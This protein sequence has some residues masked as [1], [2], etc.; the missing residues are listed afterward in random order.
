MFYNKLY[1]LIFSITPII[2]SAQSFTEMTEALD[3]GVKGFNRGVA[4][5]DFDNDGL[6]D[7]YISRLEAR[8]LLYR[9]LGNFEFEE[10]AAKYGVDSDRSTNASLFFDM[11]NDGDL[12][13]YLVNSFQRD[14]LYRNDVDSFADVSD[15]FAVGRDFGNVK[16]A[17]AADYDMDGDLDIYVTSFRSQNVLWR[18]EGTHFLNVIASSG[19]DDKGSSLGAI[20]VDYD[21]DGDQDLYQTRDGTDANLFFVNDGSGKYT[22]QSASMGL[23]FVG[24][25]MG[26]D[27]CEINGDGEPDLYLTNLEENKLYI[28]DGTGSFDEISGSSTVDD[29]GMGWSCFF[30]DCDN[31][32]LEDLYVAN[33]SYFG[34]NGKS[35]VRNRL[36]MNTGGQS[37]HSEDYIGNVQNEYGTYG[38]AFGDLDNDGKLDLV[39]ANHGT[40]DGNQIFRNTGSAANFVQIKLQGTLSNSYGIGARLQLYTAGGVQSEFVNCGSGYASQNSFISHFGLGDQDEVDSLI[41]YWPSGVTQVVS[42]VSVNTRSTVVEDPNYP[43]GEVVWTEPELPTIDDDITVYY[44]AAEGNGE[45]AGFDGTVYA[46]AGVITNQSSSPTDWKHVVGNWGTPD[47]RVRMTRVMD[48]VYT[49]SYNIRDFY[50]IPDGEIVEQLA[51]VFRNADG[52]LVGRDSDGSDIYT[53]VAPSDGLFMIVNSPSTNA[54]VRPGDSLLVDA[55]SNQS[56]FWTITNNG[57]TI[58][59]DSAEAVNIYITPDQI[60]AQSLEIT[61]I[62]EGD[63]ARYEAD[64]YAASPHTY[65]AA[66]DGVRDGLNYTDSS[67]IFQLYAPDKAFGYLLCPAN[68]FNWH[69]DFRMMRSPDSASFWIE[70]PRE[71]FSGQDQNTYQYGTEGAIIADPYSGIVLDPS[72]DNWI[73][74]HVKAELPAYPAN[75]RGRIVSVLDTIPLNYDWQVDSFVKPAKE[76]LVIYELLVR[77]F[78]EDR[79]Y[80]SLLDTLDYLEDLGVNAI[81]LMPVNE[82]EANISWGYN[83][84]FHHALDKYYGTRDDLKR[85][86]D[87]AHS[88]GMAVIIDV[89]FNHSFG[90]GPL[91]RLYWD[92]DASRPAAGSPYLNVVP[93]HP[94]NV[95]FDFNHESYPTVYFVKRTL[96]H[97]LSEY[98]VDG[99]RFDLSKGFT[100]RFSGNNAALM[101][102]YD[103]KR[104]AR[105]KDYADHVWSIDTQAYVILE[106]YAENSE[107]TELA[108][109]GMMIWGKADFE[110]A[111][112]AMGYESTLEWS[113]YTVRGW[114]DPHVVSYMESHDEERMAYKIQRWGDQ[115]A[116]YDTRE[117]STAMER[118]AAAAAIFYTI[119]GPKML[120]QFGELGYDY[121]VNYC[122]NGEIDEG[123]RTEPKPITWHYLNNEARAKLRAK[124]KAMIHLKTTYPT[125]SS[126]DFTFN[127]GNSYLKSIQLRHPEMDAVSMANYRIVNSDVNPKFTHEGWWY[128]YFSGDSVLVSDTQAKFTFSPG[129]YRIYTDQRITPP[130]GFF[131]GIFD[132]IAITEVNATPNP[133]RAGQDVLIGLDT[134]EQPEVVIMTSMTGQM[135]SPSSIRFEDRA[136]SIRIP[137]GIPPGVYVVR[138]STATNQYSGKVVVQ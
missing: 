98:H 51:F 83:V 90:L 64:Y 26:T 50:Q 104:I 113:D 61:L 31:D 15:Q 85:V 96:E 46:H 59:T 136:L 103:A 117:L 70:I 20:F 92:E 36:F 14:I 17:H 32:G 39:L 122:Q 66:P 134:Y 137:E 7:I 11:D 16:T 80:S 1:L 135:I 63:T 132:P 27:V 48:D 21:L 78:L 56:G 106:H 30:F 97:M 77:D 115:N 69:E 28:S 125:F 41:I 6:D 37:F 126:R 89:V 116:D 107:E 94:F 76:N 87:E 54:V 25:G 65:V 23:D 112:A 71:V 120:W 5:A 105:L 49:L 34:V 68:D 22:E 118:I 88:R 123:C 101:A 12:D 121:P 86:I 8:N 128:E 111:E 109:H 53:P 18:N 3:F 13:L 119:P 95:G 110:F 129:E 33:D 99:F 62:K 24:F 57:E 38:A 47:P 19:I 44:N 45:L 40:N 131:T 55:Y 60:G 82:F 108:N 2:S 73:P 4:I 84:S 58:F 79:S 130:D 72:H 133:I 9:N 127:D 81:E 102:Q 43:E 52:S 100:Q 75:G 93:R 42:E 29:I 10:V 67:F 35:K 91:A 114:N 138:I 74:E 124:I